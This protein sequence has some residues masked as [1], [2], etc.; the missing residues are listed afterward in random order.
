MSDPAE[1]FENELA[2]LVIKHL[3]I[4]QKP[5]KIIRELQLQIATIVKAY[6][7]EGDDDVDA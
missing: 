7:I 3:R 1:N 2:L 5:E 4:E 6:E